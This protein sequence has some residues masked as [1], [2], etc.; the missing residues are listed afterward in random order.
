MI[1][2]ELSRFKRIAIQC[3]DNPDADA[4][5][6]GFAL[7][8]LLAAQGKE[9]RFFYG[10]RSPV[11]KPDLVEMIRA[12]KI[13]VD[14]DPQPAALND[15][16]ILVTVDCQYG[17][18]NVT[19]VSAANVAVIDHHVQEAELPPASDVRPFLGSCSTMVWEHLRKQGF[20]PS[21]ELSTAL[22]FGL[23]SDTAG[24]SEIRH[25]LDRDMR[26]SLR[27]DLK[28][29]KTLSRRNLS[30]E[31]LSL[32]AMSLNA[33]E[34]EA[35]GRFALLEAISL[36]PNIS[37]FICD[38]IM[39]VDM[40]DM[41]VVYSLNDWGVKYSVRSAVREVKANELAAWLAI[42]GVGSGGGHQEK[43]GGSLTWANYRRL[44]GDA[45]VSAYF[46]NSMREYISAYDII[47]CAL[48]VGEFTKGMSKHRKLDAPVGYVPCAKLFPDHATLHVRMLEGDIN[49]NV[50]SETYLMIGIAG[51]VYPIKKSKFLATYSATSREFAP[52]LDYPPV[53]INWDTGAR[54][55]LIH[56][57]KA[58][59]GK[60]GL[61]WAKRLEKGAKVFT[62][63]DQEAYFLGEPG[64]WLVASLEDQS[65]IYVVKAALF[66]SL[67]A[68]V[69]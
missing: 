2:S 35:S 55:P 39:K 69:G 22:Y 7:F 4:L 54:V 3:H 49:I 13:P 59:V 33:L 48:P 44:H 31:D 65:D 12:L 52:S 40:I 66:P 15:D 62:R 20:D 46:K 43:A 11:A 10:G 18:G 23:Y 14:Y 36:D 58:C 50:D 30:L 61:A 41:A 26:D 17:A 27:P 64:D 60:G 53:V 16:E 38:L 51:E 24:F 47:D 32:A 34:Y 57:A 6:S 37:G 67:Y 5:A 1:L 9:A 45:E 63:W 21:P 42:G 8:S 29:I 25:P 19:R 56:V 28:T 68:P